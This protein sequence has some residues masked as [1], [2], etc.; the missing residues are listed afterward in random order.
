MGEGGPTRPGVLGG[1]RTSTGLISSA[2]DNP[3]RPGHGDGGETVAS[4]HGEERGRRGAARKMRC[5]CWLGQGKLE[6]AGVVAAASLAGGHG[7]HGCA[8]RVQVP[9]SEGERWREWSE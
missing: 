4:G 2:R 6:E 3:R 9:K 5:V 1:P 7:E 8:L